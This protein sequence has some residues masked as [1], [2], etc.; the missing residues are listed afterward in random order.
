MKSVPIR[1]SVGSVIADS[2]VDME[3][4][5]TLPRIGTDFMTHMINLNAE[6]HVSR[7]GARW[8]SL[9]E[10]SVAIAF[11]SGAFTSDDEHFGW[12]SHLIVWKIFLRRRFDLIRNAVPIFRGKSS[13]LL[14]ETSGRFCTHAP[15]LG[16]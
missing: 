2:G 3:T 9:C 7:A 1:G 10:I 13:K 6:L 12:E 14:S 15:K 16:K 11:S 8:F 5:P 4:D